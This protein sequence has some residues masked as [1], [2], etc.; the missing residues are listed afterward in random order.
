G[1][2]RVRRRDRAVRAGLVRRSTDGTGRER[3]LPRAGR[4]GG[5]PGRASSSVIGMTAGTGTRPGPPGGRRFLLWAVIALALL[6]VALVAGGP[7][8]GGDSLDPTSTDGNGTKA[9]V[10]LLGDSGA[11][12]SVQDTTPG[13]STDV[14][15]LLSDS[16]SQAMTDE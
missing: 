15:V 4:S 11:D 2:G 16:T 7:T 6:V 13:P 3:P 1:G 8:A 5:R 9:L 12:V 10:D 14:A